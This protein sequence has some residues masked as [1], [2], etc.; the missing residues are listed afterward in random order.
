MDDT[1]TFGFYWALSVLVMLAAPLGIAWVCN[2][3]TKRNRRIRS[4][5]RASTQGLGDASCRSG[6]KAHTQHGHRY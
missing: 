5:W 1:D 2:R 6:W 4:G 3:M